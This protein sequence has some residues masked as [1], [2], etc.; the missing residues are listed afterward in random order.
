M[1][2][3]ELRW[4]IRQA[5]GRHA[6]LDRGKHDEITTDDDGEKGLAFDTRWHVA[7]SVA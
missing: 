2:T 5:R 1:E 7:V 4:A 6:C 3:G